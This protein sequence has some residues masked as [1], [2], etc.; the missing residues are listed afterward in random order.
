MILF[1]ED[2]EYFIGDD[3]EFETL[4]ISIPSMWEKVYAELD[5]LLVTSR[6]DINNHISGIKF[7]ASGLFARKAY[8]MI[9]YEGFKLITQ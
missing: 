3:R 7:G 2:D 4:E 6:F 1:E 8:C 5:R 9:Y